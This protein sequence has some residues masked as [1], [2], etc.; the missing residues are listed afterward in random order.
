MD[1]RRYSAA[2]ARNAEPILEV[3]RGWL[4]AGGRVLEIASG[5]GQ[6]AV[7]L[8]RALPGIAWIPS[9]PDPGARHSIAAWREAEGAERVAE[10]IAL[11]VTAAEWPTDDADAIVC[12]NLLHVAPWT[13]AEGLFAGAGRILPTGGILALY[14]PFRLGGEHTA[15][16]NA[17][18]DAALR[19]RDPAWGIRDID[20]LDGLAHANGLART[21]TVIMP[22]NNRMLR[23]RRP[24]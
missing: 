6:H 9:D 17:D 1:Q 14:G 3:L 11:D 8:S 5:S 19:A 2:A 21:G 10:P 16:T 4:P 15:E 23:Y 13:A 24:G 22:A 20:D 18:F 12:I 7:A